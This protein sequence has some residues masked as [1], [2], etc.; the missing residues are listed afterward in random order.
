MKCRSSPRPAHLK[1][2]SKCNKQPPEVS[3]S[4]SPA[5]LDGLD[6]VCK[7]CKNEAQRLRFQNASPEYLAELKRRSKS[8]AYRNT[9]LM[10]LFKISL[11]DYNT[12]VLHQLDKCAICE[13]DFPDYSSRNVDHDHIT[14]KVRGLLCS[15]CNL[16]LGNF[17]DNIL[18]MQAAMNYLN[19][20]SD[21]YFGI[22]KYEGET[23]LD[24]R[25]ARVF[26][27]SQ[28]GRIRLYEAQKYQCAICTN[29]I[30]IGGKSH[31][32]HSHDGMYIRGVLCNQ[33]NFGIGQLRDNPKVVERAIQYL[34]N[35]K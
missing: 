15:K 18:N 5:T 33:C 8:D 27:I 26:R 16:A 21:K 3:F 30:T 29:K 17:K 7:N 4:I 35:N 24:T 23:P 14:N 19:R 25:I 32:D 28:E 10:R 20:A 12:M 13:E 11:D 34:I 1:R 2:C 31:I 9:V 6:T 22:L